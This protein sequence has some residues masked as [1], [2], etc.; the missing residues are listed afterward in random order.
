VAQRAIRQGRHHRT[1][2]Y[3]RMRQMSGS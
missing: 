2:S 3:P 1:V